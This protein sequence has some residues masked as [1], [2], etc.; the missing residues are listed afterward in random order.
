M[1]SPIQPVTAVDPERLEAGVTPAVRVRSVSHYFGEGETRKQVLQDNS[2]TLMPGE[3][4]IMTGP[5]GSG[6]STLL[7]LI[8]GLRRVQEGSIEVLGQELH[9]RTESELTRVRRSI[10]F[11]FQ[12]HNLFDSLTALQNVRTAL[13]HDGPPADGDRR[14]MQM[15]ERLGLGGRLH[16]KPQNLSG[17]QRQRVAIARALV[18]R[19][20]VVLADEPTAAL[21]KVSGREVINVLR[22]LATSEGTT[23]LLVTHDSRILDVADRVINMIDGRIASEI[24]VEETVRVIEFLRRCPMFENS[25]AATLTEIAQK[26][27]PQRYSSGSIIVREGEPGDTFYVIRKGKVEVR[28]ERSGAP[29]PIATLS[30]GDFFGEVALLGEGTRNATVVA[31]TDTI[32]YGLRKDDFMAALAASPSLNEQLREVF[33]RR[34]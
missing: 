31:M 10:G 33:F 23:I 32:L 13:E 22:E 16:Y 30:S 34:G 18:H 20:P 4:A 11:I 17:G 24:F 6:K 2:V 15:L 27:V 29:T 21:D 7:T 25:P 26:M 8:G 9:G 19:P 14:A 3:M 1:T 28:R 5:S 12:A